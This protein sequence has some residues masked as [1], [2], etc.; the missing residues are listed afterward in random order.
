MA[1]KPG[2]NQERRQALAVALARGRNVRQAAREAGYS[3]RQAHRHLKNDEFRQL[4]TTLRARMVDRA[5]GL[6]VAASAAAITTL[7]K[8]LDNKSPTVQLNAARSLLEQGIRYR[9]HGELLDRVDELE[10]R[11]EE[12]GGTVATQD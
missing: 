12:S 1:A 3:E 6:L 10:R 8:L 5:I 7:R 11:L 4:V 2:Q 9:E